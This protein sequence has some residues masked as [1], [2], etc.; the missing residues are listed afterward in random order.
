MTLRRIDK[1]F[2]HRHSAHCESGSVSNLLYNY[3]IEASEPLVFGIGSGIFFGYFPFIKVQGMPSITFRNMPGR[4]MKNT[5]RRLG[6]RFEKFTFKDP[7][8]A[9]DALDGMP[10]DGRLLA[11]VHA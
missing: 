8:K 4:I 11:P 10:Q 9:M 5:A 6:I 3:G 2:I 7:E 1:D